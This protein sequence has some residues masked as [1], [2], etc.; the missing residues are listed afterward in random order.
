MD[1]SF[2]YPLSLLEA[3]IK[4]LVAEA[5]NFT[6]VSGRLLD[7]LAHETRSPPSR[8]QHTSR[9]R[10]REEPVHPGIAL[11]PWCALA[12][13]DPERPQSMGDRSTMLSR[14]QNTSCMP[15]EENG[16]VLSHLDRAGIFSLSK[17]VAKRLV[18]AYTSGTP[19]PRTRASWR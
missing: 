5:G 7:I 2:N 11:T 14:A 9:A 19:G 3:R 13:T 12:P 10:P 17:R 16:V 1:D 15:G 8:A 6:S 4:A 18:Q